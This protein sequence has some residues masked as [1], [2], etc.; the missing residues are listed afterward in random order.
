MPE[1]VSFFVKPTCPVVDT[2]ST[3][4]RHQ[5]VIGDP[6]GT[7]TDE[8]QPAVPHTGGLHL[9][10]YLTDPPMVFGAPT[11]PVRANA[12]APRLCGRGALFVH[13][14]DALREA[15]DRYPAA[16]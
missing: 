16:R 5:E 10:G 4:Q 6:D 9:G 11:E 8:A 12:K 1:P 7:V 2:S 15:A 14:D 13:V 3:G